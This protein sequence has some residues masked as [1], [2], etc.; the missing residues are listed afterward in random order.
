MN[1]APKI[2]YLVRHAKSSWKDSSLAD[3]DRPLNRRGRRSA[4]DMGRRMVVQGHRPDF[5]VS[6]PAKRAISTARN[7]AKELGCRDSAILSTSGEMASVVRA[8]EQLHCEAR[9]L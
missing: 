7:I 9:G 3:R 6:S 1:T 8:V 4:P 5:I 2:L